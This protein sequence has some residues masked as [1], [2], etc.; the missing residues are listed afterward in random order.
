VFADAAATGVFDAG[1]CV[2]VDHDP[3]THQLRV[4]GRT[5]F[6]AALAADAR[7][8]YEVLLRSRI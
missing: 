2:A 4:L 8:H 1:E 6:H 3:A 5:S 7:G